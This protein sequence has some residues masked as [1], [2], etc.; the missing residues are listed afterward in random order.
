MRI[1]LDSDRK[2]LGRI[3]ATEGDQIAAEL[4]LGIS[5]LPTG[6]E[7]KPNG[8]TVKLHAPDGETSVVHQ[9]PPYSFNF[10]SGLV[11]IRAVSGKVFYERKQAAGFD[12]CKRSSRSC[13]GHGPV[14]SRH[15]FFI[16]PLG[17][18]AAL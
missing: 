12:S 2:W 17:I 1:K 10:A 7:L 3:Y 15:N 6:T 4:P 5:G 14:F 9:P 13:K 8:L 11:S 18:P 16:L